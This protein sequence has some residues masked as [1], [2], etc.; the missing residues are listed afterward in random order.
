M[1][2]SL[3]DRVRAKIALK[4]VGGRA[5]LLLERG[6]LSITFD[7]FPK[8][9]WTEGG[10]V[11]ASH[12]VRATYYVA[13]GFEGR[14]ID[15]VDQFDADDLAALTE[16]GHELGCHTFDH[17]SAL[18]TPPA[19]FAAS[20]ARNAAYVAERVPGVRLS[21][22]AYPFGDVSLAADRAVA[23]QGFSSARGIQ[24]VL[25]GRTVRPRLLAAV[26]LEDRKRAEYDFPALIEAAAREPG[27]L[28]LYAHD[29]SDRPT[30]FGCTPADLDRMLT[31]AKAAGLDIATVGA[32]MARRSGEADGRVALDAA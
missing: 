25:N 8:S 31:R 16:A 2:L 22:F 10:A 9:A 11:C 5:P 30:P 21:A 4:T 26:G 3:S 29:V 6:A 7:D 23:R 18:K 12:G 15:G 1:R 20:L 27:W 19:V 24:P 17:V 32:V 28:I 14:V 13:G